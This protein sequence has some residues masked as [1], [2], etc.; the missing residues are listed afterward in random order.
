MLQHQVAAADG[1]VGTGDELPQPY[2]YSLNQDKDG[3][4]WIGTGAG[5]VRYDGIDFELYTTADSLCDDF[6]TCSCEGPRGLW[7]GHMNG[8]ITFF[9]GS[10]FNPVVQPADAFGPVS[11]ISCVDGT[12]WATT[13]SGGIWRIGSGQ[14]PQLYQDPELAFQFYAIEPVSSHECFIGTM[15]GLFH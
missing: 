4:L 14:E 11:D 6:I 12:I 10:R 8:G 15:E 3:F 5:L 7:F 2:V 13:Q 9:D 1:N